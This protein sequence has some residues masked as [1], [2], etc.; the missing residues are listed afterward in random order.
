MRIPLHICIMSYA[1]TH[2]FSLSHTHIHTLQMY[3]LWLLKFFV[4]K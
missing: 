4:G 1:H 2:T 3:I